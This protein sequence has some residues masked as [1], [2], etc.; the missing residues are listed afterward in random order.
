MGNMKGAW[1]KLAQIVSY[2]SDGVPEAYR[3]ALAGL[4]TNAPPVPF[5]VVA[6]EIERELNA[7]LDALFVEMDREPLAAAS[8]GQVHRARLRD[9]REVAVKVQYPGVEDAIAADV[10]NLARFYPLTST[11]FR[12]METGPV[13]EEIR[14]RLL[15][16]LDYETEA[17]HQRAFGELYADHP[18]VHVPRVLDRY[19]TRRVLTTELVRGHDFEWLVE[20]SDAVRQRAAETLYRFVFGSLMQHRGFN[21]DP[22]PGNY[23]FAADG[24]VTF[25]DFGCVRYFDAH[26][27]AALRRLYQCFF[28]E[29]TDGFRREMEVLGLVPPT[30]EVSAETYYGYLA[31]FYRPFQLDEEFTYTSEHASRAAKLF[32]DPNDPQFGEVPRQSNMPPEFVFLNRL[33]W[34][35]TPLL[36]RLHA[37]NN[38]HRIHHELLGGAPA[39]ELG[40]D[41]AA[42]REAWQRRRG[43][44]PSAQV[45]LERGG[46]RWAISD[47][48]VQ[49]AARA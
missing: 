31:V 11:M 22:H 20:Q 26:T 36:A 14:Q 45:W 40:R 16:E 23:L 44:P 2:V 46:L 10:A 1:M 38:W 13:I 30:S 12:G 29:D 47:Q 48:E 49:T 28:A 5:D 39:T 4:Q 7:S 3:H 18:H 33:Q 19:S 27:V 25:L 9:G 17:A 8:I 35:L 6:V 37:R 21:G 43:I 34:G 32:M 42:H 24:R 15:E 41:F